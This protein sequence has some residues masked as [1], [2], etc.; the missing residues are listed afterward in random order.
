MARQHGIT[1]T[2]YTKFSIDSGA[3][4]KNYGEAGQALLGATRGGNTFSLESEYRV[5]EADGARGKVVGGRRITNVDAKITANFLEIDD[6]ILELAL[7]GAT[8]TDNTTYK[9]MTRA[10][11]IATSD[12]VTNIAI[13]GELTGSASVPIVCMVKN[14]ISDGG[15]ELGFTDKDESVLS[16]EFSAHFDPSD[17]DTEPWEIQWPVV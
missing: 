12:H 17:L 6:A 7:T 8:N 9:T 16:V 3:V 14:A 15:F 4:Y 11:T 5:M 2:T 13:V 1:S 10:L